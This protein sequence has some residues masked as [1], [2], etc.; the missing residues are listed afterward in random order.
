M[1]SAMSFL[2]SSK[3][4]YVPR[5]MASILFPLLACKVLSLIMRSEE[6]EIARDH[7]WYIFASSRLPD[8]PSP[9]KSE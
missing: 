7:L 3:L 9:S 4:F 1:F 2:M 6:C 5:A 8:I